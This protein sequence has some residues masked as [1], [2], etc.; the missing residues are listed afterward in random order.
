VISRRIRIQL[1]VFVLL[2]IAGIVYAGLNYIGISPIN[3]PYT[4]VADFRDS[5]G[6]FQ[7]SAVT[8]RGY[9]IGKVTNLSLIPNGVAVQLSI[10]HG[11]Q[12]PQ[13]TTALV[14]NLS[15]VGEQYVDLRP[16]TD[17]GPYLSPGAVIP[18]SRTTIPISDATLLLNLDKLLK[19]V[20]TSDL[21]EAVDQ[22]ALA[23]RDIGPSLQSLITNGDRL[24]Q[25]AVQ[26]LPQQI[27]L[28]ED[29]R[30][31][32]TTQVATSN[33]L[34]T[35]AND[36]ARFSVTNASIDADYRRLFD[37]GAASADQLTALIDENRSTLP[38]FLTNLVSLGQIQAARIP[39]LRSILVL[40]P[41]NVANGF[42]A[43]A[44]IPGVSGRSGIAHFAL[45]LTNNPPDCTAG[46]DPNRRP[47]TPQYFGGKADTNT[48]CA[49]PKSGP[50][51]V[52]GARAA[53]RP[54]GDT[55]SQPP[56]GGYQN[57]L[58]PSY[59]GVAP[60]PG[61]DYMAG[62][63]PFAGG[64]SSGSSRSGGSAGPV[65]TPYDPFNGLFTAPNGQQFQLGSTGGEQQ[66]FGSQSWEWL[67]LEPL[68]G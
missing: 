26:T 62:A 53:P 65:V 15:A 11:I 36:L 45:V 46:Y 18:M 9:T 35:F 23:F 21:S 60:P 47:N 31:V 5:G 4:I 41:L 28:I 6:V 40:Y 10:N 57:P 2:S 63:D 24:A 13:D 17:H 12:I 43:A 34:Q 8:Y 30:T 48:Y 33:E 59:Y 14:A 64:S 19:S 44:P 42:L 50:S 1:V 58:P 39:G 49:E 56:P 20:N 25:T 55:T 38:T 54:R 37:T 3:G 22:F 66:L 32:L 67:L 68:L 16:Q 52:R 27:K 7:G 61:S 29:G 51:D